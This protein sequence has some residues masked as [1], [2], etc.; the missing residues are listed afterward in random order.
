MSTNNLTFAI[1]TGA[2]DSAAQNASPGTRR[3]K[4]C[5][6]CGAKSGNASKKCKGCSKPFVKTQAHTTTRVT[7]QG[8]SWKKCPCCHKEARSN[9]QRHCDGCGHS[10]VSATRAVPTGATAAPIPTGLPADPR[11]HAGTNI[12]VNPKKRSENTKSKKRKSTSAGP[13][14]AKRA[15]PSPATQ[16][17][18]PPMTQEE[19]QNFLEGLWGPE[20]AANPSS[21]DTAA[22][23][24]ESAADMFTL[25]PFD[26]M[27][28]NESDLTQGEAEN[29][30]WMEQ[31]MAELGDPSWLQNTVQSMPMGPRVASVPIT[32]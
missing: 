9:A 13:R 24:I 5:D 6:H 14:A 19:L 10:W 28:V 32:V 22:A 7:Q 17:E 8:R 23:S 21:I 16:A 18:R 15:K 1:L 27:L 2:N 25:E 12:E 4:T 31:L 29:E 26:G 30:A 20:V 3:F 11:V